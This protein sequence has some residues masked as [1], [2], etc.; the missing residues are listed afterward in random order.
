MT[1]LTIALAYARALT[2]KHMPDRRAAIARTARSERRYA[3]RHI[4]RETVTRKL[5]E[6]AVYL[7]EQRMREDW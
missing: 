1:T 2:R 7:T 3:P 4:V 6:S 5:L